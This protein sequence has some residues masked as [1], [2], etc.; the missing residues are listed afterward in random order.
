MDKADEQRNA[1]LAGQMLFPTETPLESCAF[2]LALCPVLALKDC[3]K[4]SH[5]T[6]PCSFYNNFLRTLFTMSQC[7]FYE[8]SKEE[9]FSGLCARNNWPSSKQQV[10]FLFY[11]HWVTCFP[12]C[13]PL[14]FASELK[15]Q[16]CGLPQAN[17]E[18]FMA[19]LRFISC[20]LLLLSFFLFS[21]IIYCFLFQF[22]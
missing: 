7:P 4:Q 12:Q 11:G 21:L 16:I 2:A 3:N 17:F 9:F 19:L 5:K 18:A 15:S 10:G 13:C 6:P 8:D 20:F 22:I 1:H 14:F